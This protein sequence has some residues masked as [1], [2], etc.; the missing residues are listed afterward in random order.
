MCE[1]CTKDRQP[2]EHDNEQTVGNTGGFVNNLNFPL[3]QF[4]E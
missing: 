3:I 4:F 1:Q 2:A